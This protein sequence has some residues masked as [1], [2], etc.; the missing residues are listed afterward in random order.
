MR[1]ITRGKGTLSVVRS[2][3]KLKVDLGRTVRG[4]STS[5]DTFIGIK[6][7]FRTLSGGKSLRLL[8]CLYERIYW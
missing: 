4:S 1:G 8:E 3:R 2:S 7:H 6:G 5:V